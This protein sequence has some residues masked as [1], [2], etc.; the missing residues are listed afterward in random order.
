MVIHACDLTL[1]RLRQ[2]GHC[3]LEASQGHIERPFLKTT[4]IVIIIN[5]NK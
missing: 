5:H 4:K 2:K 1:R 3:K